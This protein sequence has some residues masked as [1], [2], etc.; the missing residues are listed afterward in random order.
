MLL[1][2]HHHSQFITHTLMIA[3]LNISCD[4]CLEI[5]EIYITI[6]RTCYLM[7]LRLDINKHLKVFSLLNVDLI[8]EM[9]FTESDTLI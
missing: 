9:I 8:N 2:L 1:P 7:I 4:S 3:I 6:L 5:Y